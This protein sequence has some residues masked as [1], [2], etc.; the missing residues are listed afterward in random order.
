MQNLWNAHS[1]EPEYTLL[2]L[3]PYLS[4]EFDKANAALGP[5]STHRLADE[6]KL[7]QSTSF[8]RQI[9]EPLIYAVFALRAAASGAVDTSAGRHHK[10]V[11]SMGSLTFLQKASSA[12]AEQIGLFAYT[13][14]EV[15]I[16]C[17]QI[18]QFYRALDLQPVLKQP[19][20]PVPYI[21]QVAQGNVPGSVLQGVSR[22]AVYHLLGV[23]GDVLTRT[24]IHLH[25]MAI[26]F[27][28]V[29]YKY[30]GSE[31]SALEGVSFSIRPGSLVC[32]V[33]YNGGGEYLRAQAP[34]LA[35]ITTAEELLDAQA[36]ARSSNS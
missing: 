3:R 29:A 9:S 18:L 11:F 2:A 4:A 12:L 17:T 26:E 31:R 10:A 36:R 32:I 23:I 14:D 28:D 15:R 19:S 24:F 16:H 27:K 1:D 33:G 5:L 8:L 13:L 21:R 20:N 25:Q 34:V 6:S 7:A 35:V 30:P 22:G